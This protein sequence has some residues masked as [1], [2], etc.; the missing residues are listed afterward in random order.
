VFLV[1]VGF[2]VTY[3]SNTVTVY[4]VL[5]EAANVSILTGP[6]DVANDCTMYLVLW[7]S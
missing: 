3:D 4:Y 6:A 7:S 2:G 5:A 1:G